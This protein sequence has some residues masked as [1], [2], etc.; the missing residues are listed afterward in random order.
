MG[1]GSRLKAME[2][3]INPN[4]DLDNSRLDAIDASLAEKAQITDVRMKAVKLGQTDMTEEFL[5][6]MAGTTP[7][8]AVPAKYSITTDRYAHKSIN[9]N[10]LSFPTVIG[11]PS[12]NLFNKDNATLDYRVT[13]DTGELVV[14][15]GWFVSEFIPVTA[16]T[17]YSITNAIFIAYYDVNHNYI[18]GASNPTLP[19][20]T[21]ANV[22]FL[23]FSYPATT[24]DST[25]IVFGSTLG[26]YESY[27]PK[28]SE[29]EITENLNNAI[30][31]KITGTLGKNLFNKENATLEYYVAS[32]HGGLQANTD[33]FTSEFI[34]VSANTQ[35]SLN[36]VTFIAYYDENQIYI[37]GATN[38][39]I[40]ITT[41]ANTAH[42]RFSGST[43]WLLKDMIVLGS[44][45]G[46]YENYGT[47]VKAEQ[48]ERYMLDESGI[49]IKPAHIFKVSPSF[50][51]STAG[52][53]ITKFNSLITAHN[54]I[55]DSSYY[56]RYLILVYPGTYD[57]WKTTWQ[58]VNGETGGSYYGIIP[59]DYVYFEST[60]IEHPEN[61]ILTW[62]GYYGFT[63]PMTTDQAMRRCLFHVSAHPCHTHIKGFTLQSKN[64]RYAFHAES[65]AAGNG[66]DWLLQNCIID[67]QGCPDGS[68][69]TGDAIGIGISAGEKGHIKNCK[70]LNAYASNNK[71]SG[72]NN[73]W[74]TAEYANGAKP[75]VTPGATLTIE[76]CDLNGND[77]QQTT[78]DNDANIFDVLN[79]I[80]CRNINNINLGFQGGA[81]VQNWKVNIENS[82]YVSK[83][84]F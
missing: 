28:V 65:G 55:T 16:N 6:Q 84:G 11:K 2:S 21:P 77:I 25:M 52:W 17:V 54:S 19:L 66:N 50:T 8:N 64:C 60:D 9:Q 69:Y 58:G 33:F 51:S 78:L 23:R 74:N 35:Y 40:P 73:G 79:I 18:S 61:Y 1:W 72:H 38:P 49:E 14:Q 44:V 32:D 53:G 43:S 3:E 80:N 36:Q 22:A 48:L 75:F 71:I 31:N 70:I 29:N 20:T 42:L 15:T 7:I 63:S 4:K 46:A 76:N 57:D 34:S 26:K 68:G 13:D 45:L 82:Q 30:N 83:S 27:T 67:W 56:N 12:K 62:D 59:K 41:P 47:K 81:T 5:Q 37:S 39:T 24:I 10:A